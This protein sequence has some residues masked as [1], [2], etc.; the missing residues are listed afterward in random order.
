M[1][2]LEK[3]NLFRINEKDLWFNDD[4]KGLQKPKCIHKGKKPISKELRFTQ[5][6][7]PR[8]EQAG[9]SGLINNN[10]NF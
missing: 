4:Q 5:R 8:H 2:K 10:L 7:L 3:N 9:P 1:S 6:Y